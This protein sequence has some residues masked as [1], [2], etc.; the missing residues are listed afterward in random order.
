MEAGRLPQVSSNENDGLV[1]C[2][3]TTS[4]ALSPNTVTSSQT[5]S[6]NTVTS[7][8]ALSQETFTTAFKLL[9]EVRKQSKRYNVDELFQLL[10][11]C[12]GHGSPEVMKRINDDWWS[13]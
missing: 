8:Q 12:F 7:S 1:T 6:P 2:F 3:E 11:A 13:A 4:Q 10:C 5:L 9:E